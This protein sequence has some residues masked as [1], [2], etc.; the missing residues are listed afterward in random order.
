M[1]GSVDVSR[2]ERKECGCGSTRGMDDGRCRYCDFSMLDLG[3]GFRAYAF[4]MLMG[5]TRRRRVNGL[6]WGGWTALLYALDGKKE[7][8]VALSGCMGA[9]Q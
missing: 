3:C 2:R 4:G 7:S 5:G 8:A 1:K 9:R 6:E